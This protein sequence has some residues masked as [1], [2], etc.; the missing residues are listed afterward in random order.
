MNLISQHHS[1]VQCIINEIYRQCFDVVMRLNTFNSSFSHLHLERLVSELIF[2]Q[3]LNVKCNTSTKETAD[4]NLTRE[5][6][7]V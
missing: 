4:A 5:T 1:C 7:L 6:R 2:G 3:A